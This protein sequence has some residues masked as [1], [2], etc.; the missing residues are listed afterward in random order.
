MKVRQPAVEGRFYPSTRSGIFDQI[1]LIEE[2]GRYPLPEIT[3]AHI[4]GGI[5]PHAGH[6]YSGH[7]TVPFFKLLQGR[8]QQTQTYIIVHPNHTGIGKEIAIDSAGSW[9]NP[10]GEIPVDRELASHMDLPFD[11]LAHVR[12]HSAEVIVPFMQYYL[13]EGFSIVPICVRDQ[14]YENAC[15]IA[16]GIVEAARRTR[17]KLMV[18]A[19]CDFSHFLN[20]EEGRRNDDLVLERILSRDSRGVE[21]GV[22]E[23]GISICGY[24]P[25]M[26][27][28]EYARAYDPE[29]SL[30]IIARG[31]S[32]EVIPSS[33]VVD[34]LSLVIFR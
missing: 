29:Y 27:L 34:Y 13:E 32:G 33:E 6:V 4:Y 22:R 5:I 15:R 23:H 9:M 14:T 12:E 21:Q 10:V 16:S 31:H 28:M 11:N 24:G 1:R 7:Q 8:K 3:P 19:S 30:H 25:I 18:L 2:E 17:R 20:P 26:A